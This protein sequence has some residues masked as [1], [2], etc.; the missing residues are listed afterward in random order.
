[1]AGIAA[2]GFFTL[3]FGYLRT[4]L[5]GVVLQSLVIAAFALL[6][7][8]GPDLRLFGAV[9]AADRIDPGRLAAEL[10]ET[11]RKLARNMNSVA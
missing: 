3:R 8:Y 10:A 5:V 6:A 4:L 2:G 7:F 9:M 1:M 11:A